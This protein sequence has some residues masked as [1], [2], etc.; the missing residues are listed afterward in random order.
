MVAG[1]NTSTPHDAPAT[2]TSAGWRYRRQPRK[3]QG[4]FSM[5]L[6]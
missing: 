5:E 4:E 1:A 6:R 3:F 2:A